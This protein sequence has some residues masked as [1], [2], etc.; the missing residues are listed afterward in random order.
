MAEVM[1]YVFD[2]VEKAVISIFSFSH[3]VFQRLLCQG[4]SIS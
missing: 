3:S 1:E 2:A 4:F